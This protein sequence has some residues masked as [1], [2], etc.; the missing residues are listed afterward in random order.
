LKALKKNGYNTVLDTCG[1]TTW[2]NLKKILKYVDLVFF[3]LKH[4]NPIKH[5]KFTGVSKMI[6]KNT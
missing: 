6:A 2:D 3:D 1:Y 4:M 5:K